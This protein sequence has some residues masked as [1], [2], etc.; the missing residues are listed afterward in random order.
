MTQLTDDI[1]LKTFVELFDT[2]MSSTNPAVKKC[3]HNLIM[4]AA[5]VHAEETKEHQKGPLGK[6]LDDV[7]NLRATVEQVRISTFYQHPPYHEPTK[8]TTSV[9][10]PIGSHIGNIT[11]K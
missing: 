9:Y 8:S 7:D 6:L 3:F 1:D 4:L 2:A 11:I 5:L 10:G